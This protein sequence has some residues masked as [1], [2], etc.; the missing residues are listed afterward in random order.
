MS[1]LDEARPGPKA[2]TAASG[3]VEDGLAAKVAFLADPSA[4]PE[5]AAVSVE[6]IETHFAYVFLA[7]RY[8]YKLKKP[9]EHGQVDYTTRA[10]RRAACELEVALNRRLAAP[11]YLG[12]VALTASGGGLALDG[13]GEPIDW[14]VHMRRLPED[15]SLD[16]LA[17]RGGPDES[18]LRALIVKLDAFYRRAARAP[19]TP[20]RYRLQLDRAGDEAALQLSAAVDGGDAQRVARVRRTQRAWL[21]E[22]A[23]LVEGRLREG[24]VVDAHGDLRPEHVFLD[25][26][27]QIIDCLEFSQALRWLDSAEELCFLSLECERIGAARVGKRLLELYVEVAGDAVA[28]ELLAFYRAQR[29]MLRGVLAVWRMR[30]AEGAAAARWLERARWYVRSA[31]DAVGRLSGD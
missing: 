20:E 29:A 3:P 28:P 6:L 30:K 13:A 2:G 15:R 4:Y 18:D 31:D 27:P 26:E 1:E 23:S 5:E 8:V 22:H 24:R 14:L 21:A 12:V 16:V 19:W 11:V 9:V 17:S 10:A 25:G 7:G